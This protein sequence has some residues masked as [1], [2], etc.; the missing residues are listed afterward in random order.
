[1]SGV[2]TEERTESVR[3]GGKPGGGGRWKG[4]PLRGEV[5]RG[6]GPW[7]GALILGVVGLSAVYRAGEW[8]GHWGE[9]ASMLHA[10]GTLMATPLAVAAGCWQGGRERRRGTGE[11]LASTTRGRLARTVSAGLPTALWAAGAFLAAA[12]LVLLAS[13]PYT[14]AGAPRLSA[15]VAST[16]LVLSGAMLGH[17]LGAL[18][19]WRITAPLA[20]I[21]TYVLLGAGSYST[22]PPHYLTP[23]TWSSYIADIP[24]WWQPLVAIGWPAGL[25]LAAVLGYAARRRWTAVVPLAVAALCGVLISEYNERMWRDDPLTRRTVCDTSVRPALCVKAVHPGLLPEVKRAL[26][27]LLDRLEGVE[28]LPAR[29][30]EGAEYA[31]M[32]PLAPYGQTQT[33]TRGRLGDP[34]LFAWAAA[35]G[36]IHRRDDCMSDDD[37]LYRLET[38][39]QEWLGSPRGHTGAQAAKG[40]RWSE[41]EAAQKAEFIR[42]FDRFAALGPEERRR[43]LSGYF[44]ALKACAPDRVPAL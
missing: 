11:L 20:G 6:T 3:A 44:G 39:L 36:L 1:M 8:Q 14:W 19:P 16:A 24:V 37:R 25:A 17:V 7:T 26:T 33:V 9:T 41:D 10:T 43:W 12:V 5:L 22:S 42:T 27:P 34:E 28:N 32:N 13:W 29:M 38:G 30:V 35:A 31:G 15:V 23:A 2:G 40:Y 21:G 18:A 4:H